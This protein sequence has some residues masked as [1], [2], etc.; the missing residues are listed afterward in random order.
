MIEINRKWNQ[1]VYQFIY[2]LSIIFFCVPW[3]H[4]KR[5][6]HRLKCSIFQNSKSN[7]I[8]LMAFK[9]LVVC[10]HGQKCGATD[11]DWVYVLCL[12]PLQFIRLHACP[13]NFYLQVFLK[14]S[15]WVLTDFNCQLISVL[16]LFEFFFFIKKQATK[17]CFKNNKNKKYFIN[18]CKRFARHVIV[19][20]LVPIQRDYIID[21]F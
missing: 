10:D 1:F 14:C 12:E 21:H 8:K 2:L 13:A 7:A 5:T 6:E 11:S 20:S 4:R 17:N 16:N 3:K 18:P 9:S 15:H 19:Y